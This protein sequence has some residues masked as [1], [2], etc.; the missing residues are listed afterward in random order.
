MTEQ[1]LQLALA[2]RNIPYR[3]THR[4]RKTLSIKV[5]PELAVEVVAPQGAGLD[6]VAQILAKRSGWIEKRL[7]YYTHINPPK[8]APQYI[9]GEIHRFL[10]QPCE[11]AV[12]R[13]IRLGVSVSKNIITVSTHYPADQA[14][15][16]S[17]L[18]DWFAARAEEIFEVRLQV[19]LPRFAN[20]DRVRPRQTRIKQMKSRWGSMNAKGDMT[21]NR[22]LIHGPV[23]AIDYVI[24]HE[25][26]H[27]LVADHSADF[28][29][30]VK[31]VMP[32]WKDRKRLLDLI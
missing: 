32:D 24:V 30:E 14:R 7:H 17:L 27:R 21:L 23:N 26:C 28:W 31:A 6:W 20:P 29:A 8:P 18:N 9:D 16:E 11:L 3:L 19:W 5:T 10:D 15:T 13:D 4:R 12:R 1:V 25:L 2:D 22:A